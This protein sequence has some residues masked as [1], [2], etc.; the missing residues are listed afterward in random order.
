MA[1]DKSKSQAST[2]AGVKF[3]VNFYDNGSVKYAA[4]QI[5]PED[6]DTLHKAGL[7]LAEKCTYEGD[8]PD[9]GNNESNDQ[10]SDDLSAAQKN[11][12]D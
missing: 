8:E 2:L 12:Q 9:S 5:Y 11:A 7:G 3:L 6:E 1:K 4:G 10:N